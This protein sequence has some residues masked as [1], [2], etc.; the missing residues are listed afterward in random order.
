LTDVKILVCPSDAGKT[1]DI[2]SDFH[3]A[4]NVPKVVSSNAYTVNT[5]A[6]VTTNTSGVP[7]KDFYPCEIRTSSSSYIY[8]AWMTSLTGVTDQADVNMGGIA[9]DASG[10]VA[11]QTKLVTSA[12]APVVALLTG[13]QFAEADAG[14]G[15][16][17]GTSPGARNKDITVPGGTIPTVPGA[18]TVM[19]LKEGIER[20][21]ITDINN[22]AGSAKAQS[23]IWV[24][25]DSI[26]INPDEF[27]HVPGGA[28]VL[29]MDGHVQF[30]KYPSVWPVNQVFAALN[31]QNWF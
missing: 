6:P 27:S 11:A 5:D 26:D 21:L 19:R 16:A 23:G 28:N 17:N 13:I 2:P 1:T 12:W 20:F 4:D 8:L 29:Y 10:A 14:V 18:L 31:N 9:H 22:P 24:M 15:G 30:L 3:S 7:N 25:S